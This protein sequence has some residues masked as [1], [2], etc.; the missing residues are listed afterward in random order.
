MATTQQAL[1]L[2]ADLLSDFAI[3]LKALVQTTATDTDSNPLIKI[4]SA[5]T[6]TAGTDG[7]LIKV[8]PL[9][10][11]LLDAL[12]N[13]QPVYGPHIIQVVT[14]ADPIGG[15]GA[16]PVTVNTLLQVFGE[17]LRKGARVEWYQSANGTAPVVA[18]ITAGNLKSVFDS[19]YQPTVSSM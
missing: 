12:G 3:R 7:A 17:V 13:A 6:G 4:G 8:L 11:F 14:E 10:T 5:S 1:D 19:L 9:T 15:A 16:D 18:S 2:A